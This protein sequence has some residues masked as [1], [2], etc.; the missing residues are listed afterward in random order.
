MI[1]PGTILVISVLL[2]LAYALLIRMYDKAFIKSNKI[3]SAA[4]AEPTLLVTVIIP[5]RN[6]SANI[7][8]C[9]SALTEGDA[10]SGSDPT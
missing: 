7:T 9:L 5:A 8:A 10:P 2:M 4:I 1:F 3:F 6:E